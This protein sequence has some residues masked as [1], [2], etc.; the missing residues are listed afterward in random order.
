M[1]QNKFYSKGIW[2]TKDFNTILSTPNLLSRYSKHFNLNKKD[3]KEVFS[4]L[5]I[6]KAIKP[7]NVKNYY[8]INNKIYYKNVDLKKNEFI[9][10]FKGKPVLKANCGNPIIKDVK[11]I[12]N[13]TVYKT[14]TNPEK[15]SIIENVKS[16]DL[17]YLT[18]ELVVRPIVIEEPETINVFESKERIINNY[19]EQIITNTNDFS[20]IPLIILPFINN[21]ESH[22]NCVPETNSLLVIIF[23]LI[24]LGLNKVKK[25]FNY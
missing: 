5:N 2:S 25:V 17:V 9:W 21:K 14:I 22:N 12:L 3:L 20:L 16:K 18:P 8:F 13:K 24:L 6:S 11:F 10:S 7:I 23:G 19:T 1:S 4:K 15:I